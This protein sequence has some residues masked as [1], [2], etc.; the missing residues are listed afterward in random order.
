MSDESFNLSEYNDVNYETY[1]DIQRYYSKAK[2]PSD[3]MNLMY[4]R[5]HKYDY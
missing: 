2:T 5:E 4:K 1:D 3:V